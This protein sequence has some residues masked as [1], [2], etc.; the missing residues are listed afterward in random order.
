MKKFIIIVGVAVVVWAVVFGVTH[1]AEHKRPVQPEQR[2]AMKRKTVSIPFQ[3]HDDG[4]WRWAPPTQSPIPDQI[5]ERR[6]IVK[7]SGKHSGRLPDWIRVYVGLPDLGLAHPRGDLSI[8]EMNAFLQGAFEIS[9]PP[10]T[11]PIENHYCRADPKELVAFKQ[12]LEI[13]SAVHRHLHSNTLE[14]VPPPPPSLERDWAFNAINRITWKEDFG[15][16]RVRK[17]G[18][19]EDPFKEFAEQ[20]LPISENIFRLSGSVEVTR[21]KDPHYSITFNLDDGWMQFRWID[22]LFP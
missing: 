9:L 3:I 1:L 20:G 6:A 17:Y 13:L 2:E 22:T 5:A 11:R 12:K 14:P 16:G 7:L 21:A 18:I 10:S 8:E 4:E 19:R 15:F